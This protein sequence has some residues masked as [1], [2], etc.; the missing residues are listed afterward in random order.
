MLTVRWMDGSVSKIEP[1]EAWVA[2]ADAPERALTGL[3]RKVLALVAVRAA[4]GAAGAL[5]D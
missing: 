3:S 1:E 4:L 5:S 2:L